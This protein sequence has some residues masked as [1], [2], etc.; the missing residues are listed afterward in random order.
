MIS[1]QKTRPSI[2]CEQGSYSRWS[3]YWV[4]DIDDALTILAIINSFKLDQSTDSNKRILSKFEGIA[5]P[6]FEQLQI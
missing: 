5:K 6:W 4:N 1:I 2:P 3:D